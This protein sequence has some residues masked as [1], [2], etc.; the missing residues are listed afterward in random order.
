MPL[1]LLLTSFLA[2]PFSLGQQGALWFL[3]LLAGTL[4]ARPEPPPP[5]L[6]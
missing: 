4:L 1:T 6:P 2:C 3:I 5:A